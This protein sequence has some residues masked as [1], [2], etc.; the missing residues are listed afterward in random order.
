LLWGRHGVECDKFSPEQM[1]HYLESSAEH[2]EN[3]VI[4]AVSG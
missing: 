2:E 4:D 1:K 3:V